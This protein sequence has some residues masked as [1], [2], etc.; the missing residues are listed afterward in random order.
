M[1]NILK[2][3]VEPDVTILEI[4]GRLAIG[5]DCQEVEWQLD[6][7]LKAQKTKVVFDL[8]ELKYIDSTGIG[9]IV[10][11]HGKLKKSGGDLRVACPQGVVDDTIRLTRVDQMI[12]L[13]PTCAAATE[14]FLASS[15][16][17]SAQS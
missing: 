9:I 15:Q 3:H 4:S 16:T 1:L 14:S 13:F 10:M 8:T 11:C 7:L 5:R 2:K 17:D 12:Q 6:D